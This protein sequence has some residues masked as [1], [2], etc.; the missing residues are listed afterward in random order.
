MHEI[1]KQYT[2]I[3]DWED[4]NTPT[5]NI[6]RATT[7]MTSL[8]DTPS[9]DECSSIMVTLTAKPI[10]RRASSRDGEILVCWCAS[11]RVKKWACTFSRLSELLWTQNSD[12]ISMQGSTNLKFKC[13]TWS[14][15]TS[16]QLF[17]SPRS[18]LS[19][20]SHSSGYVPVSLTMQ[21]LLGS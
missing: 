7:S 6:T 14:A 16:R 11:N 3:S 19:A 21:S 15:L 10:C 9:P 5:W 8:L 13:W 18:K 4:T 1:E 17:N 20:Y 12:Q 2:I